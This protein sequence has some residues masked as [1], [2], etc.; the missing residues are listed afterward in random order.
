MIFALFTCFASKAVNIEVT[1]T[2][3]TDSFMRALC[4]F[5]ARQGKIRSVISGNGTNFVGTDKELRKA[6][7]DLI[8]EQIRDFLLQRGTDWITWYTLVTLTVR[9]HCHQAI[10]LP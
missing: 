3:E 7:E 6:Q 8:Q 1:C 10:S 9:F 2:M 5:I 4:R